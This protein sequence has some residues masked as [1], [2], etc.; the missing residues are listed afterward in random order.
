MV[1]GLCRHITLNT[2]LL[3]GRSSSSRLLLLLFLATALPVPEVVRGDP[4]LTLPWLHM[5][6]VHGVNLL[7]RAAVRLV[8]AEEGYD[9]TSTAAP[10]EDVAVLEVNFALD[11][12]REEGHEEIPRPVGS[13]CQAN[14]DIPVFGRVQFTTDSPYRHVSIGL[15]FSLGLL[16]TK[17]LQ[18]S[19]PQLTAYAAMKKQEKTIN[20]VPALGV[21]LGWC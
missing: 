13:G 9:G 5:L 8:D 7:Q 6:H 20:A 11:E 10:A 12:G 15:G 16:E 2:G 17:N 21:F 18:T 19:G 3:M 4:V 1:T 14:A